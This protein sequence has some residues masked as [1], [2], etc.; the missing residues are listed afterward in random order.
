MIKKKIRK[1]DGRYLIYYSFPL[2][3]GKGGDEYLAT[4]ADDEGGV[5]DSVGDAV[6]PCAQAM[7]HNCNP[8]AGKDV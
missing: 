4:R 3:N 7:G 2:N 6:E 1:D 8:Q 5:T